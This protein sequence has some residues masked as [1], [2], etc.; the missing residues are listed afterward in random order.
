MQPRESRAKV[1]LINVELHEL[2]ISGAFALF[3]E[4]DACTSALRALARRPLHAN[5]RVDGQARF[6]RVLYLSFDA[7][8]A[9]AHCALQP[10]RSSARRARLRFPLESVEQCGRDD[11]D[12]RSDHESRLHTERVSIRPRRDCAPPELLLSCPAH[13]ENCR[14]QLHNELSYRLRD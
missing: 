5:K 2:N 12:A 11:R 10:S 7:P 3:A 4:D 13:D 9:E 14:L 8:C 6:L 1:E